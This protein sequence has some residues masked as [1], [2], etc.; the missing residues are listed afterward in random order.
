M[1]EETRQGKDWYRLDNAGVLYT[2]LQK[3]RYS[4]I[5]RFSALMTEQVDP[6]ALQRAVDKTMPR[7]P[8]FRVHMK[9]GYFWNYLE[10]NDAP[11]PFVREDMSNPCQPV[12]FN[13]DDGWLLRFFLL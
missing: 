3:E 10:F 12:R 13:E 6:I 1:A 9:R 11:G 5:Y 8:S 2:A 7:F 4:A